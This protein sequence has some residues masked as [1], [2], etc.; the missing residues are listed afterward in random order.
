M[1]AAA[2]RPPAP[3]LSDLSLVYLSVVLNKDS[4]KNIT[5]SFV[6]YKDMSEFKESNPSAISIVRQSAF[7]NDLQGEDDLV[8]IV[9][10]GV[11]IGRASCRERVSS[12][13]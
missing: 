13:V 11:E 8:N 4:N 3:S 6:N 1:F 5:R 10:M 7:I 2:L 12:P 9:V